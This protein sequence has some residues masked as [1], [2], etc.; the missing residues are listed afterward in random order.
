MVKTN[1]GRAYCEAAK[2]TQGKPWKTNWEEDT[3]P[4]NLGIFEANDSVSAYLEI[5]RNLRI[6][7]LEKAKPSSPKHRVL[8]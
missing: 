4:M 5:A 7:M 2:A 1:C 3:Q 6:Q 8:F